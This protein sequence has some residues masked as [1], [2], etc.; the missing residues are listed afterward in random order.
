MVEIAVE[1]FALA[2]RKFM[3]FAAGAIDLTHQLHGMRSRE[4]A[5]LQLPHDS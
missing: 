5:K 3:A 2:E 4:V 1:E